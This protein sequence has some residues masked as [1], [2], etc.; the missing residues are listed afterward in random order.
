MYSLEHCLFL[1]YC[2]IFLPSYFFTVLTNLLD[3]QI[4]DQDI[5]TIARDY[6]V[7]WEE[8]SP[9]LELTEPQIYSIQETFRRYE[10]QKREALVMWKR[11]KGSGATYSA[12]IAAAEM[13]SNI[14]LAGD[15]RTMLRRRLQ[16]TSTDA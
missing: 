9:H 8:I 4:T 6:L 5:A 15:V 10:D 13:V 12:F 1:I 7:S 11:N 2:C 3:A 14:R 16:N